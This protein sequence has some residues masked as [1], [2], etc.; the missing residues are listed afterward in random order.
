MTGVRVSRYF[1][2]T[3][4]MMQSWFCDSF[5]EDI[6]TPETTLHEFINSSHFA[7]LIK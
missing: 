6:L 5:R 2:K 7:S 1:V 3:E 4:M